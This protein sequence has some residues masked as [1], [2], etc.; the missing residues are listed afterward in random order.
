MP[1]C[2][3]VHKWAQMHL[4]FKQRGVRHEN[5]NCHAE[6]SK[7]TLASCLTPYCAKCMKEPL[8]FH[9]MDTETFKKTFYF[10]FLLPSWTGSSQCGELW[11][12]TQVICEEI[13]QISSVLD[14]VV[15]SAN[16]VWNGLND[17]LKRA[18]SSE[19]FVHE[20]DITAA[21]PF[22]SLGSVFFLLEEMYSVIQQVCVIVIVKI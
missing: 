20:L 22:K 21:L 18:D 5:D 10:I 6:T 13:I 3:W 11:N 4:L 1:E 14:E 8:D 16:L 7:K 2:P 17:S 19:S 12:Q 15:K 9:W